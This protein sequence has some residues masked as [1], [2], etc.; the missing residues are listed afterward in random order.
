VNI[1]IELDNPNTLIINAIFD[2]AFVVVVVVV[3]AVAAAVVVDEGLTVENV[4]LAIISPWI[5]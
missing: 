5:K 3:A 2:G 4:K 1:T